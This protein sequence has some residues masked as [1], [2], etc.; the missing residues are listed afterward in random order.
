M[1]L[2]KP[3]WELKVLAIKLRIYP[4]GN[5]A[6]HVVNN[7][8]DEIYKQGRLEY[9]TDPTLFS[10]PVFVIYKTNSYAKRKSSAIVDIQKLNNLILPDSYSLPLQ[11][12]IIANV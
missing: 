7:T 2:L 4:L 11:L 10:F 3:A 5:E 6:R 9:T 1:I 12:E 8:F